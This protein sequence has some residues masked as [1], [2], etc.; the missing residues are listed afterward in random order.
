MKKILSFIIVL[1]A[2]V[3]VTLPVFSQDTLT[4][5][6][7]KSNLI[8]VREADI[9]P[10]A[11]INLQRDSKIQR[12]EDKLEEVSQYVGIG[13]EIG[14]AVDTSLGA[15]A[16]HIDKVS[17]TSVGKFTMAM[18]AWKI[19]G[20]DAIGYLVG[21]VILTLFLSI[22]VWSWYKNFYRRKIPTKVKS[23]TWSDRWYRP[24]KRYEILEY[25]YFEKDSG[26]WGSGYW[27]SYGGASYLGHIITLVLGLVI[28]LGTCF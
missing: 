23:L 24:W 20:E 19:V 27:L 6:P 21:I 5:K 4:K 26:S 13:K 1:I 2:A 28:I 7:A 25:E 17:K 9:P 8:W 11:L 18:V 12:V 10:S 14:S 16:Y 22:W 15:L 3:A